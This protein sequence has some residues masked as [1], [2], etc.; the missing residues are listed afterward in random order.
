MDKK[1]FDYI[2]ENEELAKDTFAFIEMLQLRLQYQ[3]KVKLA[4]LDNI[5]SL[6]VHDKKEKKTNIDQEALDNLSK[7]LYIECLINQ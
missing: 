1:G 5:D 7:L 6:C 3:I 4:D 2:V